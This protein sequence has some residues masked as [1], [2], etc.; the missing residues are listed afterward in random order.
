[1]QD[2]L[3]DNM[4]TQINFLILQKNSTDWNNLVKMYYDDF[5]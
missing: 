3:Y 1:M 5:W 2:V 4:I